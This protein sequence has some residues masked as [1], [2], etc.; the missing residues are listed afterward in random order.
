MKKLIII[1]AGALVAIIIIAV[2]LF[3]FV[4]NK[5]AKPKEIVY[6][7]FE[8]GEMYSNLKDEGKVCKIK[9]SVEYTDEKMTLKLEETK[10]KLINNVLM[11]FREKTYDDLA[12]KNSQ[13]RLAEEIRSM[14][15]ESLESDEETIT[16]VYFTE[17]IVQG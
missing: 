15:I 5:P 10:S 16:N 1:G 7:D 4:F 11:I 14:I 12:K 9:V 17:F 3:V 8:L 2:L 13:E 6:H